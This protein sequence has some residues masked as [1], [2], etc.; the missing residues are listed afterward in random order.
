MAQ[1][2]K[3]ALSWTITCCNNWYSELLYF[4]DFTEFCALCCHM[5]SC[6][7]L[8]CLFSWTAN[9]SYFIHLSSSDWSFMRPFHFTN[10]T[11][12]IDLLIQLVNGH[13]SC[14]Y[15]PDSVENLLCIV[16]TNFDRRYQNTHLAFCTFIDIFHI[17]VISNTGAK[18]WEP[19]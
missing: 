7:W 17:W 8:L 18:T 14:G 1:C 5:L 16:T 10:A 4:K 9:K 13:L 15:I 2:I 19:K 11:N 12:H 3:T 6:Q